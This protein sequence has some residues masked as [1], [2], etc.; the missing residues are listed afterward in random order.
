MPAKPAAKKQRL[1]HVEIDDSIGHGASPEAE[2]DR[3]LAIAD[4][5]EFNSF[6]LSNGL[7]GPYGLRLSNM[8]GRLIFNLQCGGEA[9]KY[10]IGLSLTPFRRI[11]KD[12]FQI[13]DSYTQAVQGSNP[14]QIE[15]IDMARRALHNDGSTL[16]QTRLAGKAEMDFD[17]ARRIFTLICSLVWRSV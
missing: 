16:L 13:C 9:K 6:S 7:D 2:Q 10:S 14:Q 17:T 15:A 12:Y 5:L 11:V 4:L 8:D 1:T 3:K